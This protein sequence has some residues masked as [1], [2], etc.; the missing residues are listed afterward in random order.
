MKE[1][2]REKVSGK[3]AEGWYLLMEIAIKDFGKVTSLMEKELTSSNFQKGSL[4]G[5]GQ[6]V[7]WQEKEELVTKMAQY[8][9]AIST[10]TTDTVEVVFSMLMVRFMKVVSKT[11][12]CKDSVPWLASTTNTRE[13]GKQAKC[14]EQV[15]A[16]GTTK[17][18]NCVRLTKASTKTD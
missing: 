16:I 13:V 6:A 2:S 4:Q 5:Y 17:M 10:K 1:I 9:K 12:W 18:M 8:I 15:K 3:D 7:I 14:K 11:I